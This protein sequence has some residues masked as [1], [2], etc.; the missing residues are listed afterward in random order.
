MLKE[1]NENIGIIHLC[2]E[3]DRYYCDKNGISLFPNKNGYSS[4]M[5]F[6]LDYLGLIPLIKLITASFKVGEC[7]IKGMENKLVQPVNISYNLKLKKY[8]FKH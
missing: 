6:T 2:G 1:K 8:T 4:K 7:L 5:S 3:I